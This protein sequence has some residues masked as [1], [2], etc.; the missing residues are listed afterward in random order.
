MVQQTFWEM[1]ADTVREKTNVEAKEKLCHI[2]MEA[3]K[4]AVEA[5]LTIQLARR[6]KKINVKTYIHER[7]I[8]LAVDAQNLTDVD[9]GYCLSLLRT[10]EIPPCRYLVYPPNWSS[11]WM[12]KMV[13]Q[14]MINRS[15]ESPSLHPS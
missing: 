13:T 2:D 9:A 4:Q 7:R 10:G 8:S 12:L 15:W 1:D 3:R 5:D 6:K 14:K 11:I